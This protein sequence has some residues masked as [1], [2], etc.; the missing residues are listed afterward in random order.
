VTTVKILLS[1]AIIWGTAAMTA[2]TTITSNPTNEN[3]N[4]EIWLQDFHQLVAEMSSHYADLEWAT[5][6]RHMDLPALRA[7]TEEKIRHSRDDQS[8]KQAIEHF[9]GAFGDGHLSVSW[10]S[11]QSQPSPT[12]GTV[13]SQPLCI[14]LGFRDRSRIGVDFST[15]PDFVAVASE[16]TGLFPSGILATPQGKVGVIRIADFNEHGFPLACEITIKEMH[17]R[18][19]SACDRQCDETVTLRTA[20]FLTSTIINRANQLRSLGASAILIDVTRNDGGDDWNEAVARSLSRVPLIDE[21]RGFIKHPAWTRKL[22]NDLGNVQSDL[23]RGA[24]PRQVLEKAAAQ[25]R[26]D[27]ALSKQTCD[28]SSAFVDGSINCSLVVD[29]G[30]FWSGVLPY[31]KPGSFD[32]MRSRAILFNPL[33]YEYQERAQPL[34]LYVAVDGHSWSSAERFAALLQDNGAAT[35]IGE[36]TGGAGCGSVDGG[37]PTELAHSQARVQMPNCVGFRKDGSN[38]NAGVTPDILLPWAVRDT[39][40]LRAD[41]LWLGLIQSMRSKPTKAIR[42]Q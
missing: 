24:Q 28:M 12:T 8:A 14:R 15:L 41:K 30:L 16:N 19:D 29:G 20:N 11:K 6:Y 5:T 38:P 39:P 7:D 10:P 4:D 1:I 17:L 34:P 27:I 42:L 36:L 37:I 25:L 3:F 18:A 21:R 26:N 32:Q 31:A 33:Q 13:V 2:Q 9:L 22:T 35:I 40:F 23:D